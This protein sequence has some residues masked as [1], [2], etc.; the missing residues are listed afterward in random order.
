MHATDLA[1]AVDRMSAAVPASCAVASVEIYIRKNNAANRGAS[2]ASSRNAFARTLVEHAAISTPMQ[3][4]PGKRSPGRHSNTPFGLDR[5]RAR[6]THVPSGRAG[7]SRRHPPCPA[8]NST[9]ITFRRISLHDYTTRRR[10][11]DAGAAHTSRS[12]I[13]KRFNKMTVLTLERSLSQAP[14]AGCRRQPDACIRWRCF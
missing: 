4:V 13:E 7:S 8:L 3:L 14:R 11:R 10:F 12:N 6:Q 1:F 2:P 5:G 9:G